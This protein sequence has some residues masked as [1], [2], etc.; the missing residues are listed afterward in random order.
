PAAGFGVEAASLIQ[1]SPNT[2]GR[3]PVHCQRT[4]TTHLRKGQP[5][6]RAR[7]GHVP[8]R[9][10][11]GKFLRGASGTRPRGLLE[12]ASTGARVF[13]TR[14]NMTLTVRIATQAAKALE[15]LA[16]LRLRTAPHTEEARRLRAELREKYGLRRPDDAVACFQMVI[17]GSAFKG[18]QVAE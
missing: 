15:G 17:E 2:T 13:S 5:C 16:Q 8:C 11:D 9:A 7:Q 18:D 6:T 4:R 1:T 10:R 12:N 3:S 14:K